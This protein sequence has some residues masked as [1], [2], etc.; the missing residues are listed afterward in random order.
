MESNLD[1]CYSILVSALGKRFNREWIFRNLNFEFTSPATYAITGPNGSGKSTLL[2]VLWGQMPPSSGTLKFLEDTTEIP[3]EGVYN[4]LSIATPYLDLIEEFTLKEQL[5]FHFA[6]KKPRNGLTLTDILDKM[7]LSH[8]KDKA[9]SNFSSGMKQRTK[10]AMTF[11]TKSDILFLD[12]PGTNLDAKSF[13]W[14]K[15]N[16]EELLNKQLIFIA[17][18]QSE[19]Y[20]QNAMKIDIMDYK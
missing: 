12:E 14:Y 6:L 10:L 16:L 7:E 4:H 20:P 8:A 13:A 11:F 9:I 18:N 2:Q 5:E 17:S 19:E 15:T 3:V 1:T